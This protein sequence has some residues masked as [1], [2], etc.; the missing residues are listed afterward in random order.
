[1]NF[2]DYEIPPNG[3]GLSDS[4]TMPFTALQLVTCDDTARFFVWFNNIVALP[5]WAGLPII[6]RNREKCFSDRVFVG[7]VFF[8]DAP[9]PDLNRALP[10]G[11]R[12]RAQN[13]AITCWATK[14]PSEKGCRTRFS[15]EKPVRQMNGPVS[16]DWQMRFN[17]PYQTPGK[18]LRCS[19]GVL[20]KDANEEA[21]KNKRQAK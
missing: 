8:I 2:K 5:E 20:K 13:E 17:S 14:R 19:I 4:L 3:R 15:T 1:M 7:N 10:N 6:F 12:E 16:R 9:R 11:R 21:A 18:R